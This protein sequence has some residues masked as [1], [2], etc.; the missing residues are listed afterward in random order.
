[1]PL[2]AT[3][4]DLRDVIRNLYSVN[5]GSVELDAMKQKKTAPGTKGQRASLPWRLSSSPKTKKRR[6]KKTTKKLRKIGACA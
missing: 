3:A 2:F 4:H 6:K 1:M 5:D